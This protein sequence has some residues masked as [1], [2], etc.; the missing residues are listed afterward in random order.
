MAKGGKSKKKEAWR[1][2]PGQIGEDVHDRKGRS[3]RRGGKLLPCMEG[4][5]GKGAQLEVEKNLSTRYPNFESRPPLGKL[6]HDPR[7]Q[8]PMSQMQ[9][10]RQIPNMVSVQLIAPTLL[11]L[12]P[13]DMHPHLRFS[14]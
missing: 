5:G 1:E 11:I 9:Y 8:Q 6:F 3:A 2:F 7:S 14:T 4:E 12:F 10:Y 13:L